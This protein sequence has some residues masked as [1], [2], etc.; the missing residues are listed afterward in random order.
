MLLSIIYFHTN[1]VVSCCPISSG[2]KLAVVT[3]AGN[4]QQIKWQHNEDLQKFHTKANCVHANCEQ[5]IFLQAAFSLPMNGTVLF[6]SDLISVVVYFFFHFIIIF[7]CLVHFCFLSF[8]CNWQ[9]QTRKT[10]TFLSDSWKYVSSAH[11]IVHINVA[12]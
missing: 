6:F 12:P 7:C 2:K 1:L 9:T 3:T 10:Y 11:I 5:W 4:P 8:L